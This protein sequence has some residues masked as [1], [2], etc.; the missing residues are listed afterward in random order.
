M[1]DLAAH[2]PR[3]RRYA[4]ALTGDRHRADDLVQDTLERALTRSS[5]WRR[6][7]KLDAWLLT[8]MHNLFVN[9][10][11]TQARQATEALD[12]L[13]V[14]PAQRAMQA[15]ALEVRDLDAALAALPVEQ[16]AVL[17]LVT[18]DERS[19]EETAR[20]LD[21]P[22]GTVMSRLSRARERLRQLLDGSA[23]PA[24]KVVK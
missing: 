2:L 21:I 24:L 9:Q 17:L 11:R 6:G 18:L 3:L 19:Y 7:S 20:I 23:A 5:L 13:P 8:I 22:V 14:E 15:D 4:R 1:D 12:A 16:R 10:V